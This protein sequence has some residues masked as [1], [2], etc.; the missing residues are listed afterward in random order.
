VSEGDLSLGA[1]GGIYNQREDKL[2]VNT[3]TYDLTSDIQL[4]NV[5][6]FY[7]H[8][9]KP[10]LDAA[11]G[12]SVF[13]YILLPNRFVAMADEDQFSDEF[14]VHGTSFAKR[15]DWSLG[16]YWDRQKPAGPPRTGYVLVRRAEPG[17]GATCD[18]D[19]QGGAR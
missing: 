7:S 3:T 14:Q 10:G 17:P 9:Y 1:N 4:K 12:T 15:L 5:F 16:T 11:G 18:N 6:G 8:Y 13:P 2:I 19:E